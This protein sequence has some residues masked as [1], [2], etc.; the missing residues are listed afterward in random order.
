MSRGN[1]VEYFEMSSALRFYINVKPGVND[2]DLQLISHNIEKTFLCLTF[3]LLVFS[4][5]DLLGIYREMAHVL[6]GTDANLDLK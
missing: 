5:I 1:I 4:N 3:S 6:L 2:S